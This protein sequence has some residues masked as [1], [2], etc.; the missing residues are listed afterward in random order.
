M[1]GHGVASILPADVEGSACDNCDGGKV[2]YFEAGEFRFWICINCGLTHG[3]GMPKS[4]VRTW[5]DRAKA[6][7]MT[8]EAPRRG[9]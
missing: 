9:K 7:A 3:M 8:L 2:G 6:E 5:S 1:V 4:I